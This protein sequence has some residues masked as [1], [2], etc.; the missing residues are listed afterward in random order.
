MTALAALRRRPAAWE[1][2]PFRRLTAAWV[3]TNLGD[4]ALFLM[5]AVWAKDLTGS[6]A[7]AGIV[8]AVLG[9]STLLAPLMGH[10]AD[11]VARRPLMIVG[12]LV[13]AVLVGSLL[14]MQADTFWLLYLVMFGYGALGTLTGTAQSGLLRDIL[15]DA[16][17]A[18]ANGLLSTIDQALRLLSPLLGTA[19]YVVVGPE[20]VVILTASCFLATAALLTR[21]KIQESQPEPSGSDSYLRTALAGFRHIAG[22]PVLARTTLLIAAAFAATGLLNIVAIPVIEQ[23]L[24]LP[25]A[26]LG[27]LSS[28][29]GVGAIV[30]GAT[31]A[32][33]IGRWG[34][35]R[36]FAIGL[37][38]LALGGA[39]FLTQSPVVASIGMGAVGFGVTWA[40]V[41]YVTLRQRLT[42]PRMQGRVSA[43]GM[44]AIN[45][46]QALLTLVGAGVL[47]LVDY[48]L[49]VL[50]TVLGVAAAA[51]PAFAI[52][53]V[54]PVAPPTASAAPS[55]PGDVSPAT[56]TGSASR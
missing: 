49:L 27:V 28:V 50:L 21:V 37:S 46:P 40:V 24:G 6:D 14:L 38:M 30:G 3:T 39:G 56:G 43:A 5:A 47:A 2:P 10:V 33:V 15:P 53:R 35:P 19:L 36:V 45:V 8:F 22:T 54:P 9:I 29:Q 55:D 23:G 26:A 34:E 32:T 44:L 52:R 42:A 7:A 25:A 18:S 41:A 51:A 4:S 48:R 20:A 31:S 17:L 1:H 12:N 13:G 16:H 11:R